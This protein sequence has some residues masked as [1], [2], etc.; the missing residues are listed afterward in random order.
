MANLSTEEK[1]PID[2]GYSAAE[3]QE[4]A[5]THALLAEAESC[6]DRGNVDFHKGKVL[7]KHTAGKNFLRDACVL[8]A[9][10]LR[11]LGEADARL[12]AQ[13]VQQQ[14]WE[15]GNDNR[16]SAANASDGS[17]SST[18]SSPVPP[19][20]EQ[21]QEDDQA[22]VRPATLQDETASLS[23]R[24]DTVRP[25]L[26]LNLA[27]CNLL[28]REWTPAI[29]CCTHVLDECCGDAL[30]E[31]E[32]EIGGNNGKEGREIVAGEAQ[33]GSGAARAAASDSAGTTRG[34]A[35]AS[36]P[37]GTAA[38][39]A[40]VSPTGT[41]ARLDRGQQQQKE[42]Q[43]GEMY[44]EHQGMTSPSHRAGRE[45]ELRADPPQE[46]RGGREREAERARCREVA[47]KCLYRRAA[48]LAGGGDVATARED[49]VR[50]LR[51]K[52]RDA[53]ISRELKKAEKQLAEDEARESLRRETE[54]GRR[55]R[56]QQQQQQ[57]DSTSA[58]T[59]T[60]NI[61]PTTADGGSAPTQQLARSPAPGADHAVVAGG[62]GGNEGRMKAPENQ[63]QGPRVSKEE[64]EKR[65]CSGDEESDERS[66]ERSE[67]P[68]ST[69]NGGECRDGLYAWNQ[70]IYE[71]RPQHSSSC[72]VQV[73]VKIPAW[74]RASDVCVD[75]H[76][77]RLSV[78][79]VVP[80][81]EGDRR[82]KRPQASRGAETSVTTALP[83]ASSNAATDP[84]SQ[85]GHSEIGGE[86]KTATPVLAGALSRP[87]QVDECLWTIERPGRVLLYLQK[88][89]PADGE[90]GFE[91]WA[92]VMEGDPGVD[93][94][95]CD[96]G[97]DASRYPE[98]ARRRGAKALW[99]H[100]NKSPEERL[101]EERMRDACRQMEEEA[102][103]RQRDLD[104]AMEDPRKAELY[105]Q[106]K[107]TMPDTS[108]S[109]K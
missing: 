52:P 92:C 12:L 22:P 77:S 2:E 36:T 82:R 98:H 48:A 20:K 35:A 74:A 1:D 44:G 73:S 11:V 18:P 64:E 43:P 95:A 3:E 57:A 94:M 90:P 39:D 14:Q 68:F 104:K 8:Y 70:S 45:A 51:L 85:G 29:A 49:L 53:A 96:A 4:P 99:E 75:L 33:G 102:E 60:D 106:L 34:G 71:A 93:V 88:E 32:G 40:A 69:H 7:A 19:P 76:R 9:E 46:E 23:K 86:G 26:Y 81:A 67:Q 97:S 78:S 83:A 58:L 91:W 107:K 30:H 17:G 38:V 31:I 28:L 103:Q 84:T 80:H 101:K 65:R 27:A 66:H 87:V 59:K 55:R 16:T 25:S 15:E 41:R 105:R 62:I 42:G 63:Q 100:Q 108:I 10:G 5:T 54:E 50:A 72:R 79:V 109:I 89:L 56:Q 61:T 47:A 37:T 13:R 21:T 6:K 24:A